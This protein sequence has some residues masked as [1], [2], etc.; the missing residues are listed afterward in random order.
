MLRVDTAEI[1]DSDACP[2]AEAAVSLRDLGRINRWFGGVA[3]SRAMIERV[4]RQTGRKHFSLLEVASGFGELPQCAAQKLRRSGITLEVTLLDR[5]RSHLN[6]GSRAVVGDGLAL[7]FADNAFDLVGC[8]LFAHHL[9]PDN[10]RAFVNEALR[11]SRCAVLI[12]D[13]VRHRMHLALVYAGFLFMRTRV[14]RVDGLA[15][16]RR[17]Y[18]PEEMR[19]MLAPALGAGQ[20]MEVSRHFLFRM[21]VVVWKGAPDAQIEETLAAVDGPRAMLQT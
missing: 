17:A 3:T 21:G 2:P 16:V 7:P 5:L 11:V 1:L 18:V 19:Q 14:S 20:R 4:A 9:D 10:L 6:G 8:S 12:N 13:L 15:S